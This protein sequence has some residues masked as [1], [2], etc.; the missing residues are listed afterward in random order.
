MKNKPSTDST[1]TTLNEPSP[2]VD[3]YPQGS[4]EPST[5]KEIF[6]PF[7][8]HSLE[9]LKYEIE[10][11]KENLK[12]VDN[13]CKDPDVKQDIK[14]KIMDKH[15]YYL[16]Q[17]A[18][19]LNAVIEAAK[20]ADLNDVDADKLIKEIEDLKDNANKLSEDSKAINHRRLE[21]TDTTDTTNK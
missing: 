19:H 7:T 11:S 13:I 18:K 3:K 5:A 16:D 8:P 17:E 10:R 15:R 4:V 12:Q 6:S 21:Q 2:I 14:E 1:T 9:F 20:K